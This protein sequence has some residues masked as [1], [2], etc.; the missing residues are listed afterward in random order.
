MQQ[1]VQGT[2]EDAG[3]A[4]EVKVEQGKLKLMVEVDLAKDI[5]KIPGTSPLEEMIKGLAKTAVM[6]L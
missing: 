3:V 1:I 4:Y 5:D 6:A 2:M